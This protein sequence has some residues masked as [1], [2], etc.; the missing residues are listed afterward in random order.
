M[1]KAGNFF[2]LNSEVSLSAGH[3]RM[4]VF[5]RLDTGGIA[6]ISEVDNGKACGCFCLACDEALIARQGAVREHSFAHQSGSQCQHAMDAMLHGVIQRLIERYRRFVTPE[7][8]VS[9]SVAGPHGLVTDTRT[10][11][12][13]NVPV[14]RTKPTMGH[15]PRLRRPAAAVA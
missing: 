14:N 15:R 4:V 7:L 10:Q 5:A 8:I 13:I 11:P 12:A 6:H 2:D 1:G 3:D 9:A